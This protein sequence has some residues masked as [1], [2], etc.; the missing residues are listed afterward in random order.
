L[1]VPNEKPIA[2][3]SRWAL[4]A[5][6]ALIGATLVATVWTTQRGVGA[7]SEALER[8]QADLL[9]ESVRARV[10]EASGPLTADDLAEIAEDLEADGL[11]YLALFDADGAIAVDAGTPSV[12]R[13][14]IA[15]QLVGT[16]PGVPVRVG[17]VLR[18]VDRRTDRRPARRRA[19]R[20]PRRGAPLLIEFE[21]R[22]ADQ[23][24]S[25]AD[26]ALAI[27]ALTAGGLLLIAV[28]L[29]RWILHR[30]RL[31][32]RLV[33]ER[34]LASLGQMSAVLAHEIRNP[35]ASLKGNAQMLARGLP[36]G[37]RSRA[38][39]DRVVAEAVRL[40]TLTNDLLEFARTGA[41]RQEQVEPAALLRDAASGLP[42]DVD[43]A[44]APPIWS[45]D[46]ERIRQV[47]VNLLENAAWAA[48]EGGRVGAR[49][50][51]EAGQLVYTVR[52]HG[53]GFPEQDLPRIFE[54]F[55]TGRTDGTGLGLA[56]ARRIV[57]LHGGEITARNHPGG[58][59]ELRVAL[60]P[61]V[62][63]RARSARRVR[64]STHDGSE[65]MTR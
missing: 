31:E 51:Q 13:E 55:F 4:I 52:D 63:Q 56:V 12:S 24:R 42:V 7:A 64:G 60:P 1:P 40:E 43:A 48:G 29:F 11:R 9:R 34:R 17:G 46:R 10:A 50:A 22:V 32:R 33:E 39:A 2:R 28:V 5:A 25:S 30:E 14:A 19:A 54:P 35:L 53:P 61:V 15:R 62:G 41:I 37:D 47:L 57:E 21:P 38:R 20:L 23:L 59:A 8:G 44:T 16:R 26:R 27:G 58:G 49:V 3:W 45:L 65:K 36:D 6:A 18:M